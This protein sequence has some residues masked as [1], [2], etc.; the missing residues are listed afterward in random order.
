MTLFQ[1]LTL[2]TPSEHPDYTQL[3]SALNSLLTYRGFIHKVCSKTKGSM[4]INVCLPSFKT[5]LCNS[6]PVEKESSSRLENHG[7]TE[8]NSKLPSKLHSHRSSHLFTE[9][10]FS[11]AMKSHKASFLFLKEQE[12]SVMDSHMCLQCTICRCQCSYTQYNTVFL[13]FI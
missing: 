13:Y 12:K 7:G 2:H 9:I 4:K 8:H 5:L 11:Q 1:V 6:F 3:S 10:R